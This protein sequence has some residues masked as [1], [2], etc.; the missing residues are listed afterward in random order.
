[1]A[2]G[3]GKLEGLQTRGKRPSELTYELLFNH[4]FF[5]CK[6]DSHDKFKYLKASH[7]IAERLEREKDMLLVRTKKMTNKRYLAQIICSRC[8]DFIPLNAEFK[9][10][11]TLP[12]KK[13]QGNYHGGCW[14]NYKQAFPDIKVKEV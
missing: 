10:V 8:N 4:Y 12:G 9:Y 13:H 2:E 6:K 11:I 14:E 5:N 7:R 3:L 1:M